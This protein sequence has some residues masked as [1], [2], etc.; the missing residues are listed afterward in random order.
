[1][2]RSLFPVGCV[3]AMLSA[4]SLCGCTDSAAVSPGAL[5]QHRERLLME[6][7]PDG[8]QPVLEVR[9]ALLGVEDEHDHEGHDPSEAGH[10]DHA[11]H[12]DDEGHDHAGHDEHEGHD[13]DGEAKSTGLEQDGHDEDS[14]EHAHAGE[15]A[16]HDEE[17]EEAHGHQ[18][19]G[20]EHD[21]AGLN[22]AGHDAPKVD[23]PTEVIEVVLVGQIGGLTNPWKAAQPDFPFEKNQAKFFLADPG[24]V[25]GAEAS[26][27]NHA[28]GEECPIC[29]ANAKDTTELLAVVQ[30][31]DEKGNV[32]PIDARVLFDVKEK[33]TV[34]VR[35]KAHVT[36]G[37]ILAV[38]ATGIYVRR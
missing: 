23:L 31:V 14:D 12:D 5:A 22:T 25:A 33:D 18:E 19:H 28:P 37:G 8:V 26:G 15:Q 36:V 38:D 10:D 29:E 30:F 6:D 9:E 16:G 11:G 35:G 21:A 32:L 1:M 3:A 24:A 13:D 17:H 27:H 4:V 34:V 20:Y 2:F 7:E